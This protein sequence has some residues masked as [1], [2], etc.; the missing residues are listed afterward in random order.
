ME[1]IVLGLFE[2][3]MTVHPLFLLGLHLLLSHVG[4]DW[5]LTPAQMAASWPSVKTSVPV[6][7]ILNREATEVKHYARV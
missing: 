3:F 6:L 5:L 7:C 1:L 2:W 4:E